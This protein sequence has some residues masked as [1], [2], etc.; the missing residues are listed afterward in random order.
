VPGPDLGRVLFAAC[1]GGSQGN[2]VR[3]E[4]AGRKAAAS[5]F[6]DL[7]TKRQ[8]LGIVKVN[9]TVSGQVMIFRSTEG[10]LPDPAR[11]GSAPC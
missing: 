3:L 8:S 1:Y 11:P 7:K 4:H 9:F 5:S 10:A 6:E 2:W